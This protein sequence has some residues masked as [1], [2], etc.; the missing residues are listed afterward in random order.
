MKDKI[1][2]D[3]TGIYEK[4]QRETGQSLK[5]YSE[6]ITA[7]EKKSK[8]FWKFE[9]IKAVL[10]WCISVGMTLF[11][12]RT[13]FD[14]YEINLPIIVWKILYFLALVP[15]AGCLVIYLIGIIGAIIEKIREK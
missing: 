9:G 2:K 3:I 7:L 10:F 6:N 1:N 13:T 14:L 15:L 4:I 8:E 12:G 11:V 5:K